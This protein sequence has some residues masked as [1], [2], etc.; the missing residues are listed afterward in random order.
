MVV[1]QPSLLWFLGAVLDKFLQATA[2]HPCIGPKKHLRTA[3][4]NALVN[5]VERLEADEFTGTYLRPYDPVNSQL[6][7]S[8]NYSLEAELPA[9][10]CSMMEATASGF[11]RKT[12]WLLLTST[13]LEPARFDMNRWRSG[14]IM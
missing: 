14:A 13:T 2:G 10:A 6:Q 3:A 1:S 12:A 9:A 11:D 8:R 4:F 7:P 5:L